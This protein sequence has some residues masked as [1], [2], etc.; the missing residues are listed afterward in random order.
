MTARKRNIIHQLLYVSTGGIMKEKLTALKD[1]IFRHK[2]MGIAV[3][4]LFVIIILYRLGFRII[5][6]PEIITDWSAV[7]AAGQWATVFASVFV[8]FLSSYLTR[9]FNEKTK[10]IALS[11]VARVEI[12]KEIEERL[13]EKLEIIDALHANK[14]KAP[15][16]DM[17]IMQ[18]ILRYIELST[19]TS[20]HR[21][22]DY[23]GMDEDGIYQCLKALE[24]K[25]EIMHIGD[26]AD[27]KMPDIL[28]K[29]KH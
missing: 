24:A 3:I 6:D 19:I 11:N 23:M 26:N 5:Y 27:L 25:K 10:D 20:T 17:D 14:Q 8:A 16:N 15:K 13:N 7:G 29:K 22:A 1:G 28:W 9:K 2:K 4:L 18:E 12:V 21:I